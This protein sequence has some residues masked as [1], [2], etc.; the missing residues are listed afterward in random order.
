MKFINKQITAAVVVLGTG[1]LFLFGCAKGVDSAGVQ[2]TN[3]DLSNKT[4]VQVYNA[5]VGSTR[6]YVYVDGKAIT[7]ATIAFGG[8]YPPAGALA[9]TIEPGLHSFTI[10]DTLGTSAQPPLTFAENMQVSK[11]YT[12][13]LYDTLATPK[14]ITVN[15][16]IVVPTDTTARVRFAHFAYFPGGAPPIDIFSKK[17]N[18]NVATNL[19]VTQVTQFIPY[20]NATDSL[21]VRAAG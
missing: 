9:G 8:L 1:L 18:A 12:I 3:E 14:Q 21:I 5:L 2:E 7:G 19:A 6:N 10:R 17:L 16:N 13:F 15:T 11:Y 20:A 4:L